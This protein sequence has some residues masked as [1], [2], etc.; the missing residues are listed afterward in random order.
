[1]APKFIPG[2][3]VRL[4]SGSPDMIIRGMHYDVLTNEY[5]EDIYDCIWFDKN[6]DEKRETHFCPFREDEL[7]EI[8]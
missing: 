1:M 4:V 7:I 2:N 3:K 6:K 5:R 8:E